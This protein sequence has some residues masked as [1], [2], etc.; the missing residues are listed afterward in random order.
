M[1][2]TFTVD[3][4]VFFT[5]RKDIVYRSIYNLMQQF[6]APYSSWRG[7]MREPVKSQYRFGALLISMFSRKWDA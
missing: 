3:I 4:D 2:I 1:R 5:R 7:S 6:G